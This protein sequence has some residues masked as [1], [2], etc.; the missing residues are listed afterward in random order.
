MIPIRLFADDC[1]VYSRSQTEHDQANLNIHLPKIKDC[2]EEWQRTLN[3]EKQCLCPT[4]K[5]ASAVYNYQIDKRRLKHLQKYNYFGIW[6]TP[7]LR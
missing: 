6:F 7:D 1:V 5:K 3:S 4:T 2:Y